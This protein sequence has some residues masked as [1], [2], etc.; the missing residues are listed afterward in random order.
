MA[1]TCHPP[2]RPVRAKLPHMAPA[3]GFDA[4]AGGG[5]KDA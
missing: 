3:L 5:D 4:E 2:H 1:A